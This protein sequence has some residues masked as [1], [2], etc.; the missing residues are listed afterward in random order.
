[1]ITRP[2]F[3]PPAFWGCLLTYGLLALFT[4]MVSPLRAE[5]DYA[6]IVIVVLGDS[7]TAGYGLAEDEGLVPQ[8]QHWLIAK[9]TD[10][11]LRN[12]GVSGDTTGA[13]RERLDWALEPGAEALI[14]ELGANDLL[15]GRP[16][17]EAE[18]NLDAILAKAQARNLPVLLIGL[19]A[20]PNWGAAYKAD[21][22][23][24]YPR[25]AAKY[26]TLFAPNFFAGLGDDPRAA[27]AFMQP[28]GVHPT[29]EGVQK[30]VA[31][32]GPFVQE[33]AQKAA[34]QR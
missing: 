21:F 13:G 27:L 31:A 11:Y 24:L 22:D 33:L 25:L 6:P 2:F 10:V 28:D 8:L 4:T 9:G 3:R 7:L 16:P 26:Q 30:I 18:A 32:L 1:M 14:V 17:E 19:Q 20:P 23:A 5:S 15:R 12:A 34:A 29:G